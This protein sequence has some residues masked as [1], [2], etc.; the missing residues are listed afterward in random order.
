MSN[1]LSAAVSQLRYV[2]PPNVI[3]PSLPVLT[4][5]TQYDFT[6]GFAENHDEICIVLHPYSERPGHNE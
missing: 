2:E 1:A 5:Y 4:P 6:R 3:C